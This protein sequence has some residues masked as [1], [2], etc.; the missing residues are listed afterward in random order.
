MVLVVEN[1][2]TPAMGADWKRIMKSAFLRDGVF[3]IMVSA[4]KYSDVTGMSKLS[5]VLYDGDNDLV[6]RANLFQHGRKGR[7]PRNRN[8]SL[9]LR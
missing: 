2:E 5:I 9:P 1:I 8:G 6:E 3:N 7:K 4:E